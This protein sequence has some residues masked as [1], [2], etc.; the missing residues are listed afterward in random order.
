MYLGKDGEP[1]DRA[2][3][4]PIGTNSRISFDV[5]QKKKA[6]GLDQPT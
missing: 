1:F 5:V 6:P 3:S 2:A 4:S